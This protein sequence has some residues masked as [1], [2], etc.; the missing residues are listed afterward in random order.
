MSFDK[1]VRRILK[2]QNMFLSSGAMHIYTVQYAIHSISLNLEVWSVDWT[3][4][5]NVLLFELAEHKLICRYN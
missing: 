2:C 3:S 5:N 1:H 4:C